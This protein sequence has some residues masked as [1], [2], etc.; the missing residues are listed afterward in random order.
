[1][2]EALVYVNRISSAQSKLKI[3]SSQ[4]F[5]LLVAEFAISVCAY[6]LANNFLLFTIVTTLAFTCMI[7]IYC[8]RMEIA[9]FHVDHL[10]RADIKKYY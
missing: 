4:M 6:F 3:F 7:M 5:V 1:M 9:Y 8:V 2:Q 10:E